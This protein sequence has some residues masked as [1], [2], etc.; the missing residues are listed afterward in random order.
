MTSHEHESE[1]DRIC[2]D[3]RRKWISPDPASI[4]AQVGRAPLELRKPLLRRLLQAEV[5]LTLQSGMHPDES[6]YIDAFPHEQSLIESLLEDSDSTI[7]GPTSSA[8]IRGPVVTPSRK[9]GPYKLL[10]LI[11]EGGMGTV[12]MAEQEE[13]INR[14]VAMKLIKPG[15]GSRETIARFEA[16]RQALALMNHPNIARVLDAGQT[17]R[18]TPYFVMELVKGIP[19][20]QYCDENRLG[21]RERLELFVPVC[22]AI[23]HAHQK[24]IIHR[25]V[26]PSNVLVTL[27]GD[28]AIPKVID[29]GLAKALDHTTRLTDKTMFTEFG[30]VVGTLQYMSPEQA[31]TNAMDVDTRTDIYSLGVMLYELLTGS[32]PL[33]KETL[34]KNSI[35]KVL[36]IIREAE[37]PTPSA[38]VGT[39]SM[40]AT[41]KISHARQ[42]APVKLRQTLRG[43]LD[44]IVMKSLEKDRRRRFETASGF[45]EDIERYL[46]EEAIQARP[47]S[48]LYRVRKF[49]WR[50]RGW[51]GTAA[52]ILLTFLVSGIFLYR[53]AMDANI[54]RKEA[55][56]RTVELNLSQA[57]V[58]ES[59]ARANYQLAVARWRDNQPAE[60]I[61]LLQ[62]IP[63]EHRN[64]EWYVDRRAFEG[65]YL[66]GFGHT[67][68]VISVAMTPDRKHVLSAAQNGKVIRWNADTGSIEKV[69]VTQHTEELRRMALSPDGT[70][71]A[72]CGSNNVV[73]MYDSRTGEQLNAFEHSGMVRA[74]CFSPDGTKLVGGST[75]GSARLWDVDSGE[76]VE[77]RFARN[78][79]DEGGEIGIWSVAFHPSGRRFATG[80]FDGQIH[81]WSLEGDKVC[82]LKGHRSEYPGGKAVLSLDF[83][84]DGTLLAS[85]S[86]DRKIKLTN[87]VTRRIR[88]LIDHRLRF[89]CVRFSP[90]GTRLASASLD[91]SIKVFDV[92]LG[93]PIQ[94]MSG[95]LASVNS[96]AFSADGSRLVSGAGDKS[97]KLWN[98]EVDGRKFRFS[99]LPTVIDAYD[100]DPD[101]GA[102]AIVTADGRLVTRSIRDRSSESKMAEF[103]NTWAGR[104]GYRARSVSFSSKDS[105]L[106]IG[107]VPKDPGNGEK[108]PEK[109]PCV[110]L[111]DA[112]N[113]EETGNFPLDSEPTTMTFAP[114]GASLGVGCQSGETVLFHSSTEK[115]I[116]SP[117]S[118]AISSVNFDSKGKRLVAGTEHGIVGIWDVESGKRLMSPPPQSDQATDVG[119]T[120]LAIR[121]ACFSPAGVLAICTRKGVFIWDPESAEVTRTISE[122]VEAHGCVFNHDGSRL[123]IAWNQGTLSI[124]DTK[125]WEEVRKTADA[126]KHRISKPK[127]CRNGSYLAIVHARSIEIQTV[128][129]NA[130]YRL[131][132]IP[133]GYRRPQLSM[134]DDGKYIQITDVSG[135]S[136]TLDTQTG[137]VAELEPSNATWKAVPIVSEVKRK[138]TRYQHLLIENDQLVLVDNESVSERWEMPYRKHEAELNLRWHVDLARE[139]YAKM[140]WY[141]TTFHRAWEHEIRPGSRPGK[142]RLRNSLQRWQREFEPANVCGD[143]PGDTAS[144]VVPIHQY[145]SPFVRSKLRK[146]NFLKD[147]E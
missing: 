37:P 138:D 79:A 35:L 87:L 109:K 20:T 95:H 80:M 108:L 42:I 45:A 1:I 107:L 93:K 89:N 67:A 104:H 41:S 23:Q 4:K 141:A 8:F 7:G 137:A 88:T 98:F 2:E 81:I 53:F 111:I 17:E 5:K 100:V 99:I 36:E 130:A 114:D 51:V 18:N 83:N 29:F 50:H 118:G 65:G 101:H 43:E 66:T 55:E 147:K 27:D 44:W 64:F 56:A 59:L 72:T 135:S 15:M 31:V 71:F 32:T 102:I 124:W 70:R 139:A 126:R 12:W 3:F 144:S 120:P 106:A 133:A 129:R 6:I 84:P 119:R 19:I 142:Q 145:L 61:Q 63:P 60:A 14:R 134:S 54:A 39:S 92:E 73:N 11:G 28:E 30:K 62:Q 94:T 122:L 125:N 90:D 116:Y 105:L 24:G 96:V 76:A 40:D 38:R 47:Q 9:I 77:C 146:L 136:A 97:W 123:A 110:L 10:Q 85:S 16:E 140:D 22:R 33:E 91:R 74:I 143:I 69:F 52:A 48:S 75:D 121:S 78:D 112:E 26:K 128:A 57:K 46:N 34:G 58:V 127:F 86:Y 82:T 115:K 21:I 103:V 13:P 131:Y 113:V 117:G 25:D 68:E 49:A 132:G